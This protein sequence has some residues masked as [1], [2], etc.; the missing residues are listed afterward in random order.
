MK[1]R[2]LTIL[3]M[4]SLPFVAV[5]MYGYLSQFGFKIDCYKTPAA[6]PPY[7]HLELFLDRGRMGLWSEYWNTP[8]KP[9][10][11]RLNWVGHAL[12]PQ[13]P[14]IRRSLWEF[15]AHTLPNGNGS[16]PRMFI[17][18]FP[19]WCLLLP[20]LIAP[21]LWLR[22]HRHRGRAQQRGFPLDHAIVAR[23]SCP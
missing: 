20:C 16:P 21:A 14:D 23:A 6:S 22:R 3:A 8:G 15:D 2:I 19:I 13:L 18:A 11:A 5:L 7:R 1:H 12:M 4:L 9:Y 10:R 17:F